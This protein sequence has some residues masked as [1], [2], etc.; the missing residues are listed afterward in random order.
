VEDPSLTEHR[1]DTAE[2]RPVVDFSRIASRIATRLQARRNPRC[3]QLLFAGAL[4]IFAAALYLSYRTLSGVA[5]DWRWLALIAALVPV[6][7]LLA[8][9]EYQ[10]C[11]RILG[12]R[13]QLSDALR[14]SILST[15]ANLLPL[16]GALLVRTQALK[17]RG[18]QYGHAFSSTAALGGGWVATALLIAGGMQL[19]AGNWAVGLVFAAGGVLALS[20]TA[21]LAQLARAPV[22][23]TLIGI[24]ILE[25][26]FVLV[27]A[28]RLY[29]ALR[30]I[31]IDASA[32][33]AATLTI[34]AALASAAGI[35]PG[36]LGL[37]ELIAGAL[38]PLTSLPV[39]AGVLGAAVDRLVGLIVLSIAT[40][41]VL[42]TSGNR[43]PAERDYPGD[44]GGAR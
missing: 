1:H 11:G 16:P 20:L 17:L 23:S 36:G 13:I 15:S 42:A 27:A 21:A 18:S 10:L 24:V 2:D 43:R 12:H 33:Q 8:G 5:L 22:R 7:L 39:A 3:E 6:T 25:T 34:A 41:A 31:G 35:F 4:A 26:V 30:G 37:R 44:T 29:A 9:M 28:V 14:I 32:T 19:S 40:A 38:S